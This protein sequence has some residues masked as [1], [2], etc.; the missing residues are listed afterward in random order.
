VVPLFDVDFPSVEFQ[1]R[2]ADLN[3]EGMWSKYSISLAEML[4]DKIFSFHVV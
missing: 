3:V 1:V 2:E 4:V